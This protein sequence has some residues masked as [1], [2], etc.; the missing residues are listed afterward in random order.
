MRVQ[1]GAVLGTSNFWYICSEVHF[2]GSAASLFWTLD[3][4]QILSLDLSTSMIH[5]YGGNLC[6]LPGRRED[7]PLD[8]VTRHCCDG[9]QAREINR[10]EGE[11]I[12]PGSTGSRWQRSEGSRGLQ[13]PSLEHVASLSKFSTRDVT[14]IALAKGKSEIREI[15]EKPQAK[16]LSSVLGLGIAGWQG[17]L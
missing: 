2:Q 6:P 14:A 17:L 8:K 15:R 1:T 4:A 16:R 9:N 7:K 10:W 12:C 5:P 3:F 13:T 11:D